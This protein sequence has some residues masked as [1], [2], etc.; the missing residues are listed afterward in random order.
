MKHTTHA[1]ISL[2]RRHLMMAGIAGVAGAALPAGLLA[3][4]RDAAVAGE[5]GAG[6]LVL[7]GR[8]L[9][10]D[11]KPLAGATIEVWHRDFPR[12]A[13]TTTDGDGRWLLTTEYSG[14]ADRMRYRVSRD[15]RRTPARQLALAQPQRDEAGVW[16]ATVGT[17]A[18]T[19][20]A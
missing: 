13:D 8:V 3:A 1:T 11:G 5:T 2:R 15:G 12:R 17:T 9:G 18:S 6:K 14:R 7:S 10:R 4:P 19:S 20:L 16:R